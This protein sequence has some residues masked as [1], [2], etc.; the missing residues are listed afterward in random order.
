MIS[1]AW[2]SVNAWSVHFDGELYEACTGQKREAVEKCR[3]RDPL[4]SVLPAEK[5]MEV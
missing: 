4:F 5:K 1:V 3:N 2:G